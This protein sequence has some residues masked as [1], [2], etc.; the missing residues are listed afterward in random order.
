MQLKGNVRRLAGIAL[1]G[2]AWICGILGAQRC[3][4]E[5][6]I[7]LSGIISVT[8]VVMAWGWLRGPQAGHPLSLKL[9]PI[10]TLACISFQFYTWFPNHARFTIPLAIT[11]VLGVVWV[12]IMGLLAVSSAWE[13]DR[14]SGI[15]RNYFESEDGL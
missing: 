5:S 14:L 1:I 3:T 4:E 7:V 12:S 8:M 9:L 2:L 15:K 13:A 6:P 10:V 11:C